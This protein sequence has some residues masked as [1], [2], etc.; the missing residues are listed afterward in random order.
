MGRQKNAVLLC[1]ITACNA[2]INQQT[3]EISHQF[4]FYSQM[5]RCYFEV[6]ITPWTHKVHIPVA[7]CHQD[8]SPWEPDLQVISH[9]E[10]SLA[11]TAEVNIEVGNS[12]TELSQSFSLK[13]HGCFSLEK[14]TQKTRPALTECLAIQLCICFSKTKLHM[15]T[16]CHSFTLHAL[17]E[18][19]STPRKLCCTCFVMNLHRAMMETSL[20]HSTCDYNTEESFATVG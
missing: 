17:A 11:W 12:C 3:P 18:L 4:P 15:N 16:C 8:L 14:A 9:H 5:L 20:N 13:A 7:H 6:W 1:P 19:P 2:E 10:F